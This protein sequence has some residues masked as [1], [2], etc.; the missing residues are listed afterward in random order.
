MPKPAARKQPIKRTI[1]RILTGGKL[2]NT[3]RY[4]KNIVKSKIK[5]LPGI[6]SFTKKAL[7]KK[8]PSGQPYAIFSKYTR[9]HQPLEPIVLNTADMNEIRRLIQTIGSKMKIT[10][11]FV[12][13]KSENRC[14]EYKIYYKSPGLNQPK[15][16]DISDHV[17]NGNLTKWPTNVAN[18]IGFII[19]I[20]SNIP[21]A[22]TKL[23]FNAR[24]LANNRPL[25]KLIDALN[26][27]LGASS[28]APNMQAKE[29][30]RESIDAAL[31]SQI[32]SL[33]SGR[34]ANSFPPMADLYAINFNTIVS[35]LVSE[36]NTFYKNPPKNN[37]NSIIDDDQYKAHK[38]VSNTFTSTKLPKPRIFIYSYKNTVDDN[39]ELKL[40]ELT[41][42][43]IENPTQFEYILQPFAATSPRASVLDYYTELM[44]ILQSGGGAKVILIGNREMY[45][46]C[47]Q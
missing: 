35:K 8:L 15:T 23:S 9:Q 22:T 33:K 6:R 30:N 47:E 37:S 1:K 3:F 19:G 25:S 4:Y 14:Y 28:L 41:A 32:Q 2:S 16:T 39:I 24:N 18:N 20:P 44:Q 45:N 43:N 40:F 12:K 27:I 11:I 36:L 29:F 7:L 21:T 31:A 5:L 46:D 34:G 10:G 13:I 42:Q 17:V 26:Y 38:I